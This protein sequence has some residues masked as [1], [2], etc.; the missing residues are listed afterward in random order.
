M[1]HERLEDLLGLV[2]SLIQ[3]KDTNLRREIP[4]AEQRIPGNAILGVR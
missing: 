1:S 4:A 3:R 2:G